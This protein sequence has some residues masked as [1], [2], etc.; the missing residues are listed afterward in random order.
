MRRLKARPPHHRL[1]RRNAD[2]RGSTG[3]LL[4]LLLHDFDVFQVT[5]PH[6]ERVAE[7]FDSSGDSEHFPLEILF[8]LDAELLDLVCVP[9]NSKLI[10]DQRSSKL[11]TIFEVGVGT[12]RV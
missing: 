6:H 7:M 12:A 4:A 9:P 1:S 5:H 10:T 11:A 2:C 3:C 8:R